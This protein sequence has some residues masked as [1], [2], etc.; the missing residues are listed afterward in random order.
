MAQQFKRKI[1]PPVYVVLGCLLMAALDRYWPVTEL[2][3]SPWERAGYAV[4]A[5][6]LLIVIWAAGSFRR[7]RTPLIPFREPTALV[8]AGLYRITRNPMYLGMTLLLAGVAIR[9]GSLSPWLLIPVFVIVID[10]RFIRQEEQLME[11]QFG[12]SYRSYKGRVRRWL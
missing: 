1:Y 3:H 11:A 4:F 10:R 6:G 2:I 7:E 12:D 5:V 9:L 8:E